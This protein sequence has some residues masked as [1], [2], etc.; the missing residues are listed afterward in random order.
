[1]PGGIAL[2]KVAILHRT[3]S[4]KII[5]YARECTML[6]YEVGSIPRR[7]KNGI[8]QV[9]QVVSLVSGGCNPC[10][11]QHLV[12]VELLE[13]LYDGLK[14]WCDLL[15]G[16]ILLKASRLKG[17]NTRAVCLP[18]MLPECLWRFVVAEPKFIH[19]IQRALCTGVLK[20]LDDLTGGV[21][22][23]IVAVLIEGAI[24]LVRPQSMNSPR[25]RLSNVKI[26]ELCMNQYS[27]RTK[28]TASIDGVSSGGAGKNWGLGTFGGTNVVTG[29]MDFEFHRR[30]LV[31]LGSERCLLVRAAARD[32]KLIGLGEGCGNAGI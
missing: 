8:L 31:Q 20:R 1:M 28:H 32:G 23:G 13:Q 21:C 15:C 24:T 26:P 25:I 3:L 2:D 4:T 16:G 19:N 14:V 18:L 30:T 27:S 29:G 11:R 9:T 12:G 22:T 6:A 7:L 10:V 17:G 5:L